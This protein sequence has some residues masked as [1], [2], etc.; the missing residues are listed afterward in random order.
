MII[1]TLSIIIFSIYYIK[2]I[3]QTGLSPLLI[4]FIGGIFL[5]FFYFEHIIGGIP[6]F[7]S[8]EITYMSA[9]KSVTQFSD[10]FL[11]YLI[12]D[13]MLE[14]DLSFNGFMLKM[15]NIPIA[16][17]TILVLWHI[18]KNKKIFLLPVVLPYFSFLATKNLRDIPILCLSFLSIFMFYSRKSSYV[19]VGCISL[20]M[21][22]FLRPFA[23]GVITIIILLQIIYQVGKKLIK[24]KVYKKHIKKLVVLF[25]ITL[26]LIPLFGG[27]ITMNIEKNLNRFIYF[28]IGGGQEERAESRALHYTSGNKLK[29]F[30]VAGIRYIFTPIP[31]SIIIRAAVGESEW[32]LVDDLIRIFNQIIYYIL[33]GYLIMNARY[34]PKIFTKMTYGQKAV[35]LYLLSYWPIYSLYL[36]GV[37]HQRLKMPF[38]IAIFLIAILIKNYKKRI[39]IHN[40]EQYERL[41]NR[42]VATSRQ[43][44]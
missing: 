14:Y 4:F 26:I 5:V 33:L 28:V 19:V 29:D 37:G 44:S 34:I 1:F 9:A 23:A 10:R 6:L 12:N 43:F 17:S 40:K 32:G 20:G 22:F 36:Y 2:N 11:W 24:L 18:F 7:Y 31:T 16:A 39:I 25:I 8:D 35:I 13:F 41:L 42:G 27:N 21:L 38:Q 15:I 3:K 30:T